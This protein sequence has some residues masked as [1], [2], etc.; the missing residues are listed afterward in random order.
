LVVVVALLHLCAIGINPNANRDA[1]LALARRRQKAD[2]LWVPDESPIQVIEGD[3]G[4]G[5]TKGHLAGCLLLAA[6]ALILLAP[7]GLRFATGMKSNPDWHPEVVGPG[8]EA[9]VYFPVTVNSIKGMWNG[10]PRVALLNAGELASTQPAPPL[11]ATTRA[12]SW[13]NT[14]RYESKEKNNL[15]PLWVRVRLPNDPALAGKTLHLRLD[16]DVRYPFEVGSNPAG[17]TTFLVKE[18]A[19]THTT[20]L[21]LSQPGAA[22]GYLVAWWGC[23]TIAIGLAFLAGTVLASCSRSFRDKALPS[24]VFVPETPASDEDRWRRAI[25]DAPHQDKWFRARHEEQN[26]D[27]DEPERDDRYR[28]C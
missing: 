10:T 20:F 19:H 28:R 5:L 9:Y 14:I 11:T 4:N 1:N 17:N 15:S 16:L 23:S 2:E 26:R 24:K 18:E 22:T 3:V 27:S 8:D 25:E 6:A 13:G 7:V 21:T 12:D